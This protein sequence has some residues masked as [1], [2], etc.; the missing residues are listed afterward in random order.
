MVLPS[1]DQLGYPA[2][3][4]G[5][6][7]SSMACL[8]SRSRTLPP[9]MY[10][11]LCCMFEE[12]ENLMPASRSIGWAS[13]ESGTWVRCW[14][15]S[16][17]PPRGEMRAFGVGGESTIVMMRG[18]GSFHVCCATAGAIRQTAA[19]AM[20]AS[21]GNVLE[22]GDDRAMNPP[23][24]MNGF[25]RRTSRKYSTSPSADDADETDEILSSV[26]H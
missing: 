3:P 17:F 12:G 26:L 4:S 18:A 25:E 2:F 20:P 14:M 11:V 9:V 15:S 24:S 22:T 19:R 13:S 5:G 10:D 23:S 21:R 7:R 6:K 1:G 16:I 8:V